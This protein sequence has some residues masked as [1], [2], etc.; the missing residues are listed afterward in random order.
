MGL[1]ISPKD[2][3][4]SLDIGLTHDGN[5]VNLTLVKLVNSGNPNVISSFP[6][7]SNESGSLY[8]DSAKTHVE[9]Y[10][11]QGAIGNWELSVL[12]ENTNGFHWSSVKESMVFL[13]TF[14]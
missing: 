6:G 1:R 12:P 7:W 8:Q 14:L 3:Y 2:K 11:V 10:K 5:P 4:P 13:H 9:T